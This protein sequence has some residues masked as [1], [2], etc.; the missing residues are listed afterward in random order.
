VTTARLRLAAAALIGALAAFWFYLSSASVSSAVEAGTLS[1]TV[2]VGVGLASAINLAALV[3][4]AV[5]A[6]Y[7][8]RGKATYFWFVIVVLAAN[9]AAS[10][11]DQ[12]GVVDAIYLLVSLV[13]IGLT[14]A[15]RRRSL[16]QLRGEPA[17]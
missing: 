14:I 16:R 10:L 11:A 6:Y 13:A 17:Q 7:L 2:L 9:C 4:A 12:F 3:L 5:A 8:P 1:T 15:L